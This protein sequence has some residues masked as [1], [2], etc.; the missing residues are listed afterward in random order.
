MLPDLLRGG[1]G[2]DG[3]PGGTDWT[4]TYWHLGFSPADNY[5]LEKYAE[6]C[7]AENKH[8][9]PQ[10]IQSPAAVMRFVPP[11][12]SDCRENELR[13]ETLPLLPIAVG[14]SHTRNDNLVL[15]AIIHDA[16]TDDPNER[17]WQDNLVDRVQRLA[18]RF[19]VDVWF[20]RKGGLQ[21]H[22][23]AFVKNALE[24][25]ESG[26]ALVQSADA[27]EFFTI[28]AHE[29]VAGLTQNSVIFS[30]PTDFTKL[31]D[32]GGVIFD[33][34]TNES[35][36]ES[37]DGPLP[38]N[39]LRANGKTVELEPKPYKLVEFFWNRPLNDRVLVDTVAQKMWKPNQ[40][41]T[42]DGFANAVTKANA[43]LLEVGTAWTLSQKDGFV[44]KS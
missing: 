19:A 30:A 44:L 26:T 22:E 17:F 23:F 11:A 27:A 25:I 41:W 29:P 33:P 20:T 13:V 2:Q 39:Q 42:P 36:I 37:H 14:A 38:P 32:H 7:R 16:L 5:I 1:G 15:L 9:E 31:P 21:Q 43:A 40:T 35:S 24:E 12:L 18:D 34:R 10:Q 3:T 6:E 4:P 8:P 28:V